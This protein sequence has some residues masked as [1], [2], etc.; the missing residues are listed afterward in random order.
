MVFEIWYFGLNF[1]KKR[2]F[3]VVFRSETLFCRVKKPKILGFFLARFFFSKI[4]IF[5]KFSDPNQRRVSTE[6][7]LQWLPKV[8]DTSKYDFRLI[9]PALKPP[10]RL[11]FLT[12]NSRFLF[13]VSIHKFF[14]EIS[15]ETT[16]NDTQI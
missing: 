13:S 14:G 10:V 12:S 2:S 11:C 8:G 9:Q 3:E 6:I 1:F 16:L 15:V 7:P 4:I 5:L